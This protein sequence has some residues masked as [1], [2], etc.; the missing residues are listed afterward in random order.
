MRQIIIGGFVC[1][2]IVTVWQLVPVDW[3]PWRHG[4]LKVISEQQQVTEVLKPRT[5]RPGVYIFPSPPPPLNAR[6][7][8]EQF[9]AYQQALAEYLAT[10]RNGPVGMLFYHPAGI[11]TNLASRIQNAMAANMLTALAAGVILWMSL[12]VAKRYWQRVVVVVMLSVFGGLAAY[13]PA[14]IWQ[15]FLLEFILALGWD[16]VLSWLLA[17]LVLAAIIR[18]EPQPAEEPV[19]EDVDA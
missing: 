2:A 1:M 4:V 3:M 8:P 13:G 18:P 7:T 12:G 9:D 6:P 5:G 11:D 17:G 14:F 16:L 19:E 15:D 10:R